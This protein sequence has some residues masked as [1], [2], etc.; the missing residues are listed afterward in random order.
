MI[1][2]TLPTLRVAVQGTGGRSPRSESRTIRPGVL[3]SLLAN[4]EAQTFANE[5]RKPRTLRG[6]AIKR[7]EDAPGGW[8]RN[9]GKVEYM[10]QGDLAVT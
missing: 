9:E 10:N 3:A 6:S 7:C 5:Q 1:L 2:D 4:D 8:R